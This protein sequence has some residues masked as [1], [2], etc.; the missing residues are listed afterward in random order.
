MKTFSQSERSCEASF[1][2][3][4]HFWHAYTS[5]KDTPLL[6]SDRDGFRLAMNIIAQAANMHPQI[7]ILAFEVMSNHFHFVVSSPNKTELL[8]FWESVRRRLLRFDQNAKS[9]ALSTKSIESLKALRN[10]IVYTNRNGY[11]ADHKYTPF[12]YPWGT[13]R[14]YYLDSSD[15]VELK[16]IFTINK[17]AMFRSRTP[18]LPDHWR[19]SDGYVLP[20]SYCAINY[21]M[22]MFRDAHH[23]FAMISKNV[24]SYAELAVELDDSEFLTDSELFSQVMTALRTDYGVASFKELSK[25]QKYDLAHQ[26]RR[27]F[28]SSNG[29]IRRVLG[30][31]QYEI[32]TLFPLTA[33]SAK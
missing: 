20:T 3:G 1:L 29:Q 30:L 18:E 4:G 15:G 16:N 8:E 26:L 25:A 13:G 23:Y 28:R 17:R 33:S 31:N 19:V 7:R 21:G 6:F 14:Y 2:S 12:S 9:I 10:N 22:A 32:D 11:V 27:K 24:E 5:G